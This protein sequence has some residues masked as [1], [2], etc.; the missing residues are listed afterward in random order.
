MSKYEH[1]QVSC[2]IPA[3][4]EERGISK[5][6]EI[7]TKHPLINEII[8]IDDGSKDNTKEIIKNF[9]NVKLITHKQNMGKS[10]GLYDGI[11][12]SRMDFILFLDADLVGL[13]TQ[14]I[15]DLISPLINNVADISI[16]LRG[17]TP[18]IWR[19][20]GIDYISG[21]RVLS[22]NLITP[23]LNEIVSLR[24]FGFEVFLNEIIIKNSCRIKVV[25]WPN[26]SSPYKIS[27][28]GFWSG[29]RGDLRMMLDISKTIPIFRM[30]YQI[31][32]LKSLL[33]M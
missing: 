13:N 4:N 3:Y 27:K 18:K 17:N 10:M 9:D 11:R 6:L 33:V 2:I 5:V 21:E 20:I 15:T 16:S 19:R 30:I 8:V 24:S 14:N 29:L 26:V 12:K 28:V 31:I 22:R 23:H 1:K 32:K 25:P 7:A